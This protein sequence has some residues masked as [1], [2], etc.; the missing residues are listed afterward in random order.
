MCSHCESPHPVA[1]ICPTKSAHRGLSAFSAA[2]LRRPGSRSRRSSFVCTAS[3]CPRLS[4]VYCQPLWLLSDPL[5]QLVRYLAHD[6][7]LRRRRTRAERD[8]R[9]PS[10]A[11]RI[12]AA[13]TRFLVRRSLQRD[14]LR[15]ADIG[16]LLHDVPLPSPCP[17]RLSYFSMLRFLLRILA[18]LGQMH[19][20]GMLPFG[21]SFRLVP[22][23]STWSKIIC[24]KRTMR[25][26]DERC[27]DERDG[28]R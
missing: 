19:F 22:F 11:C 27:R 4:V 10:L 5:P 20:C 21:L 13:L 2:D 24:R 26:R 17:A 28:R 12:C 1:P 25:R 23:C 9:T 7:L 16:P 3:F 14:F 8:W 18:R 15:V 6:L